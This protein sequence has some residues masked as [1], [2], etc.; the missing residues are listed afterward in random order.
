MEQPTRKRRLARYTEARVYSLVAAGIGTTIEIDDYLSGALDVRLR[1][2]AVEIAEE[3]LLKLERQGEVSRD[4]GVGLRGEDHWFTTGHMS[5]G[6]CPN[7]VEC[8]GALRVVM[9]G[10][11]RLKCDACG[12]RFVENQSFREQE[13]RHQA[14]QQLAR[15]FF[16]RKADD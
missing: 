13:E 12:A 10:A 15:L 3:A 4:I 8:G 11:W 7:D 5:G 6:P 1:G 16:A 14:H 2:A 9:S